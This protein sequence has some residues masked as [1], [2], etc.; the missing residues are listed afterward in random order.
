MRADAARCNELKHMIADRADEIDIAAGGAREDCDPYDQGT[1][2]TQQAVDFARLATGKATPADLYVDRWLSSSTYGERSKADAR[3][4]IG[5]FKT[6]CGTA[7]QGF[8][9][10]VITDRNASEHLCSGQ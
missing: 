10:E 7:Q 2:S 4:A 6:W 1:P 8:F 9:I 5:Q 3:M